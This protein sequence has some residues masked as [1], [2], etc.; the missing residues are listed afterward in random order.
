MNLLT[1]S[2]LY[3]NAAQPRHGLFVEQRL[4]FLLASGQVTSRVV[5][6]VGWFPF[7]SP[8]FG[9]YALL[10]HVPWQERRHDID[11]IHP[12]FPI[13]PK[14]GMSVAPHLLAYAMKPVFARLVQS[15]IK[16]DVIDAHYFYPDGV[17]AA[18]LG[19]WFR[20]P[21]VITARG[22]DINLLPQYR[23]PRRQIV[24]A[25]AQAHALITVCQALKDTMVRL[26]IDPRKITPL[27]NGVNLELFKPMDRQALRK[28]LGMQA[29]TLLS[30]GNLIP[31]KGHHILIDA[32]PALPD[33]HLVII[34]E[35]TLEAQLKQQAHQRGV[36]ERVQFVHGKSHHE[37]AEYYNAADAL[38]LASERE[39]MANVL[40]EALACGTPVV[41]TRLGG[42]LEV[43][44]DA[45]AG[46]LME[47]R[48]PAAFVE[49]VK[50]LFAHYP[51]RHATRRYSEQFSWDA[52]TQGQLDIFSTIVRHTT[53]AVPS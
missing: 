34:G 45:C 53:S 32:M 47:A 50:H 42:T 3:P 30:V 12:R 2:T 40:L 43:V 25:A 41:A 16:I 18:I 17:A 46:V 29:R 26:G 35:G 14:I 27:R 38:A 19:K 44:A 49:A 6:P 22:S 51:D 37:L 4:R 1:F 15:G 7:K 23:I 9:S 8:V 5:A 33:F 39:G 10:A 11:I 31:L 28:K 52:T 13:L 21:V 48:E 20:V 36:A 24:W